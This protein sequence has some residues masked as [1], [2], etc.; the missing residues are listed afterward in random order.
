MSKL[1]YCMPCGV[2]HIPRDAVVM[3]DDE[4]MCAAHA[5]VY[6]RRGAERDGPAGAAAGVKVPPPAIASTKPAAG[7]DGVGNEG[8][9]MAK[10]RIS[11][12]VHAKVRAEYGTMTDSALQRKYGLGGGTVA[13][14]CRDLPRSK[15]QRLVTAT[16]AGR[17]VSPAVVAAQGPE[18]L[19][20]LRLP[21]AALDRIWNALDLTDKARAIQFLV[22]EYR[23]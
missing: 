14:L 8:K 23:N 10:R 22:S 5:G 15:K 12:G 19:A 1:G 20:T 7:V 3:V 6:Q 21:A 4:P 11:E 16:P 2:E 18:E 9:R 13:W 17:D